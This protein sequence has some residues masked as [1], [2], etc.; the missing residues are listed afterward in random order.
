M[1]VDEGETTSYDKEDHV[2]M[3]KVSNTEKLGVHLEESEEHETAMEDDDEIPS[4]SRKQ[5][6]EDLL[7]SD[8]EDFSAKRN[9]SRKLI[10]S[11][12]SE[13]EQVEPDG[14][15]EEELLDIPHS[16][17]AVKSSVVPGRVLDPDIYGDEGDSSDD[18]MDSRKKKTY[19]RN[20]SGLSSNEDDE[21]K[22]RTDKEQSKKA[23]K[24]KVQ[25]KAS[26]K[27]RAKILQAITS[28]TQKLVREKSISL[29]YHKPKQLTLDQFLKKR[30]QAK[31]AV[32]STIAQQP[33]AL[34]SMLNTLV[35]L[36]EDILPVIAK[37]EEEKKDILKDSTVNGK[38]LE[39]EDDD[40][41]EDML[42]R[43]NVTG[44]YQPSKEKVG[45]W[46]EKEVTTIC[47]DEP[48]GD[49][50]TTSKCTELNYSI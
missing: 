24:K 22:E 30:N 12:E 50:A 45:G 42:E 29:P 48:A 35:K 11:D 7:S 8:E 19:E 6:N 18:G 37:A 47:E 41:D 9:V 16:N 21:W 1:V 13:E 14:D 5:A 3:E 25:R 44:E 15:E 33:S 31:S 39:E 26:A 17:Q 38:G 49:D 32:F 2:T 34:G 43:P 4:T 27:S 36:Q 20:S 46:L 23:D 28:E 10:L 40:D